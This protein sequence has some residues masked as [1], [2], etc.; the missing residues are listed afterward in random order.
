MN[1][2]RIIFGFII[3]SVLIGMYV[4]VNYTKLQ[5]VYSVNKSIIEKTQ[6]MK[7]MI[8]GQTVGIKLLASRSTCYER[9]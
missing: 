7:F 1:K 3:L 2:K 9:R 8:G 6:D 5:S 4:G